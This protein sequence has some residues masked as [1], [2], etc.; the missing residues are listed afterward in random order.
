[1]TMN[2]IS[3]RTFVRSAALATGGLLA[4]CSRTSKPTT[5]RRLVIDDPGGDWQKAAIEAYYR[6]FQVETGIEVI[7]SEGEAPPGKLKAVP[8]G[9]KVEWDLVVLPAYLA[10]RAAKDGL[11][12]SINLRDLNASS[13][14]PGAVLPHFV[15]ND[16]VATV[17]AYDKRKWPPGT[18]PRTWDEFWNVKQFPGRRAFSGSGYGPLELAVLAD[19]ASPQRLYP[20]DV[21]R[22]L[23]RMNAIKPHVSVWWTNGAQ[24]TQLM[25]SGGVD[26]VM[27]SN[28][29]I[30]S[31]IDQA[32]PFAI[33][34]NQGMYQTEGWVALK[35]AANRENAVTFL[36]FALRPDRQADFAKRLGGRG[37]VNRQA[38]ASIAPAR[39]A[40]LPTAERNLSR[41]FP[42][43]V[44]WVAQNLDQLQRQWT[45][46]K[47]GRTA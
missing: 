19:G 21:K 27:A 25:T 17:M 7:H 6:P 4:A 34:W 36:R 5:P 40:Q 37:P 43:D 15:G 39:A 16:V 38:L 46:W 8:A 41:M 18:A 42:L 20:L 13:F 32:A 45:D 30:Q 11:V 28:A 29:M 47:A 3:R 2:G 31:A 35:G 24:L 12:D 44:E 14:I 33:E 9:G 22:A 10:T 1:M 23:R 26:L